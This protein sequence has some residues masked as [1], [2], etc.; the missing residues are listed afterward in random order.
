L[1]KLAGLGKDFDD[2]RPAV[3]SQACRAER[4]VLG[5]DRLFLELWSREKAPAA[6]LHLN[7][8]YKTVQSLPDFNPRE[9]A[10]LLAAFENELPAAPDTST[11]RDP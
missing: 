6:D 8:L 11:R 5:L 7:L 3:F 10:K 1:R 4:V 2:S 9:F